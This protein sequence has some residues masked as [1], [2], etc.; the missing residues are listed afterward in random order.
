[1]RRF[2]G[3]LLTAGS[4]A[5][6]TA[7]VV[8]LNGAGQFPLDP[9]RR[10]LGHGW[11]A[12]LID[13]L[14]RDRVDVPHS[15]PADERYPY[16]GVAWCCR[17]FP[18]LTRN[19]GGHVRLRFGAA[20]AGARVRLNGDE[21]GRHEGG[22]TPFEFDITKA[23]AEGDNSLAPEVDIVAGEIGGLSFEQTLPPAQAKRWEPHHPNPS[24]IVLDR[25]VDFR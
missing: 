3:L 11:A 23:L 20:F 9:L 2:L 19:S 7:R 13:G 6:A 17:A 24:R 14:G 16:I 12:A 25:E 18:A 21:A 10:G 15:R 8:S 5:A 4:L 1:M 22:Y